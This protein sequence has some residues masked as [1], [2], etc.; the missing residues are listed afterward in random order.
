MLHNSCGPKK[1]KIEQKLSLSSPCKLGRG[2]M[3]LPDRP[4]SS[5]RSTSS[6]RSSQESKVSAG[7]GHVAAGPIQ[8]FATLDVEPQ[9]PK[10][11]TQPS[12]KIHLIERV[13]VPRALFLKP[14]DKFPVKPLPQRDEER[15]L[16][17]AAMT[18]ETLIYG[19][20]EDTVVVVQMRHA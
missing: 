18:Q 9:Q 12:R 1:D 8:K 16:S 6:I 19:W 17:K 3:F 14:F 10:T 20:G 15:K 4:I 7:N 5:E 13:L 11:E 2:E